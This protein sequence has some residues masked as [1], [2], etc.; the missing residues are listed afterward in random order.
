MRVKE[1]LR[2]NKG[3]IIGSGIGLVLFVIVI[4]FVPE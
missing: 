2:E 1:W 4:L 3:V